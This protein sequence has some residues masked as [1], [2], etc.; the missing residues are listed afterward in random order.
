MGLATAQGYVCGRNQCLSLPTCYPS[1]SSVAI[2]IFSSDSYDKRHLGIALS[3]QTTYPV[4]ESCAL[5]L[6]LLVIPKIILLNPV[7]GTNGKVKLQ[8][9]QQTNLLK[10]GIQSLYNIYYTKIKT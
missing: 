4:P 6:N 7:T 5:I 3:L 9:T 2:R 8:E 1:Q 10:I